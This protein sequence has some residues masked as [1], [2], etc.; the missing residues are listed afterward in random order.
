MLY[1]KIQHKGWG[2]VANTA[3]GEEYM[4]LLLICWFC[5]GGLVSIFCSDG[6]GALLLGRLVLQV[7]EP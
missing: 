4:V 5:V 3:R 2:R 1:D 7:D 6:S